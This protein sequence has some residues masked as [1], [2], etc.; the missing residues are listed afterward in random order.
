[1][2]EVRSPTIPH[3]LSFGLDFSIQEPC[4]LLWGS[5]VIIDTL[6]DKGYNPNIPP[7]GIFGFTL[8][9]FPTL[10]ET[11]LMTTAEAATVECSD[12]RVTQISFFERYRDFLLSRETILTFLNAVLLIAGFGLWLAGQNQ[13]SRWSYLASA[14]IGGTPLFLFAAKGLIIRHDI[15]AGVMASTAMIAAIIV[16]EYSA[17]ALVVFMM[18][19]GE[20]MENFTVARADHA[21][22]DL[23][24]LIPP[25]VTVRRD[26]QEKT[27]PVEQVVLGDLVLVRTGERIGIDGNVMSGSGSVNQAAITGESM[28]VEKQA[29]DE[30]FAGTLNE[31]GALE[32]KVTRL[33]E[34]TTLGRIVRLVKDAQA[35]QAPVQRVANKYAKFLVPVTFSIAILVYALTGDILR[36]I[37][38]LVVVCPCALVLATPTAVVA[39]IGNAAR[40]AML[41][42]SGAVIEQVG[43]IDVVAFDKTGTLTLGKPAVKEVLSV[44]GISADQLLVYAATAERFSEHPIG[45]ALVTASQERRLKLGEP[46]G[47]SALPG[48]GITA[49]VD[50]RRVTI[51]N[52][53][54]LVEKGIAWTP[55]LDERL[56]SLERQGGTVVPVAIDAQVAGLISLVDLPRP[57][58]RQAIA[59][60][61]EAGVREVIMITGDNPHTAEMISKELGIDRF[62]AGVLPQD[63]LKIIRDLQAAGN[64]VLFAGDGVNDGPALAAADVGVAM[65]LAGTD[66]ALETADIGLMADEIER[67]PQIIKLSQ[68]ALS[69]IRQNVV[70]SMSMNVLSVFL[71]SFG[72]IGP[73][74]GALMHELS[75]LPVLANSSRLINY[76]IS[77]KR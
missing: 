71:G 17:A 73:V 16:G 39:A 28:P 65:G 29:G 38:V 72:I 19:V 56:Q 37:T 43:K 64:K 11:R 58:A 2:G 76:R 69:V 1:V 61:K 22:R 36:S 35:T 31:L 30:V 20:W 14:L 7:G 68:K 23:A 25:T 55:E 5:N 15:T 18:A 52:R 59:D 77:G 33:G 40:R 32:I 75:A 47:F 6:S 49:Q 70:F 34:D 26:G 27:I 50:S 9:G 12:C 67:L 21:L 3:L 62:Y 44:D 48:Y 74:V 8:S 51:G 41:V 4:H 10:K 60:L 24:K 13:W 57:E 42:K 53:S 66:L 54:L 63:K 45:K 46:V